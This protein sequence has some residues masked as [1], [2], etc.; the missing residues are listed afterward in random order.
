MENKQWL[1]WNLWKINSIDVSTDVH[2]SSVS[3]IFLS[4]SGKY[5]SNTSVTEGREGLTFVLMSYRKK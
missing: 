1:I 2:V 3:F 5:Y 4:Y